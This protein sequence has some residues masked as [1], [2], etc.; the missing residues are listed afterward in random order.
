MCHDH[1][2]SLVEL[3]WGEGGWRKKGKGEQERG[4][5]GRIGSRGGKEGGR[6]E[7]ERG[8]EVREEGRERK[9][10]GGVDRVGEGMTDEV[11]E[12]EAVKL[13]EMMKRLNE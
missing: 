8:R 11:K 12:R 5:M 3:V 10:E 2:Q 1:W 7:Q 13:V 9:G 6:G 4:G